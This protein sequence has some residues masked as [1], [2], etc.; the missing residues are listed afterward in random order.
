MSGEILAKFDRLENVL[1]R[2]SNI[3]VS[4]ECVDALKWIK[5]EYQR[6]EKIV[7]EHDKKLLGD[8]NDIL[9]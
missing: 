1:G 2:M 3:I 9:F 5:A 4:K 8:C 7:E 6:L